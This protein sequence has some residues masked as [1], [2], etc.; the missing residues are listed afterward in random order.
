MQQKTLI[1]GLQTPRR[2][3]EQGAGG[4]NLKE[5]RR[6][7]TEAQMQGVIKACKAP[8]RRIGLS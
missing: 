3:K 6:G 8:L 4:K 2:S 5:V 1:K 7:K